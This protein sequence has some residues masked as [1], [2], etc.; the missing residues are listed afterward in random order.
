MSSFV[1][2]TV[3]LI[4]HTWL[5]TGQGGSCPRAEVSGHLKLSSRDPLISTLVQSSTELEFK[6]LYKATI[7]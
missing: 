3:T 1:Y 6:D 7:I 2:N 4:F 5:A